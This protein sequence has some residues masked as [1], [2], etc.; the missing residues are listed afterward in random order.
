MSVQTIYPSDLSKLR[1][2]IEVAY[3][4]QKIGF[5]EYSEARDVLNKLRCYT[6]EAR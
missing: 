4:E 3:K 5:R 2:I 6:T 1:D